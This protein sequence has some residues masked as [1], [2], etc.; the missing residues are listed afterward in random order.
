MEY[1]LTPTLSAW[2]L[3]GLTALEPIFWETLFLDQ[4]YDFSLLSLNSF[5]THF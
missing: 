1:D 4:L 3:R 2:P 5:Y